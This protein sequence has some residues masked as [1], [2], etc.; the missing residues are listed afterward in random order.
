MFLFLLPVFAEVDRI[1]TDPHCQQ[2]EHTSLN[3]RSLRREL[4]R[5][6]RK[7]LNEDE[8]LQLRIEISLEYIKNVEEFDQRLEA[9]REECFFGTVSLLYY[10]CQH[11]NEKNRDFRESFQILDD[12]YGRVHWNL[13]NQAKWTVTDEAIWKLRQKILDLPRLKKFNIIKPKIY[14]YSRDLS[15]DL[16][17]ITEGASFCIF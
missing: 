17:K 14:V 12:M 11:E 8:S 7:I 15:N 3:W 1:W 2:V 5:I 4:L 16:R 6:Q 13:L 10:I 9:L